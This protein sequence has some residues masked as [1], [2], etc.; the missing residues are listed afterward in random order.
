M[1]DIVPEGA[2]VFYLEHGLDALVPFFDALLGNTSAPRAVHRV[3]ERNTGGEKVA[4]SP[5]DLAQIGRIYKADFA[6]FGYVLG[7]KMPKAPAPVLSAEI[8]AARDAEL[9]AAGSAGAKMGK[10]VG[11]IRRKMS[12]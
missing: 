9:K 7:E 3:N 12:G 8:I 4:P 1:D 6:R 2:H 10:L 5:S 11:K